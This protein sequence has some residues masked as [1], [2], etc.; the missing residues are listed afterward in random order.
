MRA[1]VFYCRNNKRKGKTSV[2]QKIVNCQLS[3]V[4]CQFGPNCQLSTVNCQLTR[5]GCFVR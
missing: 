4:H 1:S 2:P 5:R 3:I